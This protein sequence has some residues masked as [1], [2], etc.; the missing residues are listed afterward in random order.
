MFQYFP[1]RCVLPKCSNVIS[2]KC[3]V[4][5]VFIFLRRIKIKSFKTSSLLFRLLQWM[6][7]CL[8]AVINKWFHCT[9]DWNTKFL[10]TERRVFLQAGW[11]FLGLRVE[12][13]FVYRK[14]IRESDHSIYD[15]LPWLK[16]Q[17]RSWIS[18]NKNAMKYVKTKCVHVGNRK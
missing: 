3:K 7:N 9:P 16:W 1:N 12:V 13:I 14:W 2:P 8:H 18:N 11:S 17:S 15:S 4:A 6:R 5:R 10:F